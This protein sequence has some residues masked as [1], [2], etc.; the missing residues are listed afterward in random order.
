MSSLS[1][2]PRLTVPTPQNV[3]PTQGESWS[4]YWTVI[5]GMTLLMFVIFLAANGQLQAWLNLFIY[6]T[7]DV[8]QV[9][10]GS[11]G[12]ALGNAITGT[13][14]GLGGPGTISPSTVQG[15]GD[16]LNSLGIN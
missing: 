13:L 4:T 12:S 2:V 11:S 8:Q 3:L 6:S 5:T 14:N 1:K 9:S 16:T 7:P 10:S 15:I